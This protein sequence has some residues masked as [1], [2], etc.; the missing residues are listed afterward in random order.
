[1]EM[2][3]RLDCCKTTGLPLGMN[4]FGYR[5]DYLQEAIQGLEG[6]IIETGWP[7]VFPAMTEIIMH[8]RTRPY[9][10]FTL[11]Y[12]Q[13]LRFFEKVIKGLGSLINKATDDQIIEYVLRSKAYTENENC[14]REYMENFQKRMDSE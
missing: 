2:L 14:A 12:V 11:D 10:R 4:V 3:D 8:S 6:K 5:V 9:L 1:M 13:D 7:R